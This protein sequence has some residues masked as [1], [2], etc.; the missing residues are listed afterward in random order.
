LRRQKNSAAA[1]LSSGDGQSSQP[2]IKIG[3]CARVENMGGLDGVYF[4]TGI[5]HRIDARAGYTNT[6]KCIPQDIAFPRP[7]H[8]RQRI[9]N[10]QSAVVVDNADPENQGRVAVRFPWLPDEQT[11]WIRIANPYAGDSRGFYAI[12]E[13]GDEVL[14]GFQNGNPDRPVVIGSLYNALL[15]PEE[16]APDPDNNRKMFCSRGG[17]KIVFH[18][19]DG[20]EKIEITTEVDKN[21]ITLDMQAQTI[22]I[23]SAAQVTLTS[24]K[25]TLQ[26]KD[27]IELSADG[28][29]T[30]EAGGKIEMKADQDLK[31][32]GMSVAA[33]GQT[34]LE[35]KSTGTA[36]LEGATV[37]VKGSAVVNVQGGL[38][39]L[40]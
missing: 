40:N 27:S 24:E 28:D 14:V 19:D 4:V 17:N 38:I 3:Q 5:H 2:L 35:V 20:S 15:P 29:I 8:S 9:T 26:A 16:S 25:I 10:L 31:M 18:D 7:K 23:D 6:F 39:K 11:I 32:K 21:T 33:E 12:P 34:G 30:L 37:E 1:E 13:I 22:T 36:K